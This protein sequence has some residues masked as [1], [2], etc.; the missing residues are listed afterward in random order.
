[1]RLKL[2][3]NLVFITG[4]TM[5]ISAA[6]AQAYFRVL[7]PVAYG[8]CLFGHPRDLTSSIINNLFG[9]NWTIHGAFIIFP[10][11]LVIGVLIGSILSAY[12][13]KEFEI[14]PGPIRKKFPAFMFGFLVVNFGLLWGACPIRTALLASYGYVMAVIVIAS[15]IAGVLLAIMYIRIRVRKESFK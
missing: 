7:P 4:L 2:G 1:M 10:S 14:R 5:G 6:A 15:I 8:I 13:N 12:R 3:F 9:T 11:L